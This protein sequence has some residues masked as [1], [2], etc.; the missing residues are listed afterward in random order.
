[1]SVPH[2]LAASPARAAR[3][4]DPALLSRAS[5]ATDPAAAAVWQ[6][7]AAA[8]SKADVQREGR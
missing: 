2:P 7:V 1:M 8:L 4:Y 6:G 5:M 3:T